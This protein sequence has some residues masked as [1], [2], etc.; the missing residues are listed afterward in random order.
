MLAV[1]RDCQMSA[2]SLFDDFKFLRKTKKDVIIAIVL[3]V[4]R[5][6]SSAFG[7]PVILKYF[8]SILFG[9]CRSTA[10]Y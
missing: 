1:M 3:G 7:I 2:W 4:I 9:T 5:G 8:S 10:L 6:L